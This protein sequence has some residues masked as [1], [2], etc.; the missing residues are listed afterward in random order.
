[1]TS[2]LAH[3]SSHEWWSTN[4]RIYSNY[5]NQYQHGLSSHSGLSAPC[6]GYSFQDDLRNTGTD[7]VAVA[8]AT[9]NLSGYSTSDDTKTEQIKTVKSTTQK[10]KRKIK[11][12]PGN[13]SPDGGSAKKSRRHSEENGVCVARKRRLAANARERRRMHSLN[14]AF[15][16]L[17]KVVPSMSNDRQLS[18]YDTLQMAQTYITALLD[19]LQEPKTEPDETEAS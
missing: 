2:S 16:R 19:L 3:D 9:T 6:K 8:I 10:C 13:S 11:T 7:D 5:S 18:K 17:R 14:V 1:M 12:P 15:D 4:D